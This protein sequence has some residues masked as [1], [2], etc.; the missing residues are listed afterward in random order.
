MAKLKSQMLILVNMIVH[1]ICRSH[2]GEGSGVG[3]LGCN[4]TWTCR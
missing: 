2:G 1:E 4:S 3:L